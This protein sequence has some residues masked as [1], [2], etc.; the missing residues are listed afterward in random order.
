VI[1]LLNYFNDPA[2]IREFGTHIKLLGIKSSLEVGY[3]SGE[4]V[5]ELRSQGIICEGLDSVGMLNEPYLYNVSLEDFITRNKKRYDMVF[6]SGVLEHYD[7]EE[8][9]KMIQIMADLSTKYI[10][11][12]VPNSNCLV[13]KRA[14]NIWGKPWRDEL[15][16]TEQGIGKLSAEALQQRNTSVTTGTMA[17]EW[18][19]RFGSEESE[20][21]LV[22]ALIKLN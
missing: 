8:A 5:H 18:I 6:S 22:Y 17:A 15:D 3:R 7:A 12:L 20:P 19:K 9:K 13:Y 1:E 4:L 14:K 21:Y 2:F 10:L 11:N 16:F